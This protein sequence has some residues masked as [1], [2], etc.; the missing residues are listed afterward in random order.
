MALEKNPPELEK[1]PK[2]SQPSAVV[3]QIT[4]NQNFHQEEI[5]THFYSIA[6]YSLPDY[7]PLN[8]SASLTQEDIHS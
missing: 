4:P 2:L 3:Q 7:N 8:I 5:A 1:K 6:F